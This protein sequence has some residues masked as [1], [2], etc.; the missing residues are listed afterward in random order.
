MIKQFSSCQIVG[1]GRAKTL[2]FP[3][4][5]LKIPANFDLEEG[6]YGVFILLDNLRYLGAMHYGMSPTFS[7]KEKSLEVFLINKKN[8]SVV[9]NKINVQIIKY[10]RPVKNFASKVELIKQIEEDIE[11]IKSFSN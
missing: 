7:D 11:N 2:G 1:R 3:T 6:I 4:I 8:I 10:L 9:N 5:N